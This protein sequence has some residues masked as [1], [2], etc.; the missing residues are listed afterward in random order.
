MQEFRVLMGHDTPGYA[1][2]G[3]Y[4]D[5]GGY[6]ALRK[7]LHQMTPTEV[8]DEVYWSG[9]R[10]RGGAGF[11]TGMKWRFIDRSSPVPKY[12]VVNADEGEPG[13]FKDRFIME[14]VPHRVIEGI[15]IACHAVGAAKAYIYLRGELALC[16]ER[17]YDG[18]RGRPAGQGSSAPA[19]RLKVSTSISLYTAAPA[20]PSAARRRPSWTR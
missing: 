8:T 11:C 20:R 17:P 16:R 19:S 3:V 1:S 2:I 6:E 5:H 9:L 13:T 15:L 18:D 14:H 7:A 10:G 12:V 4:R